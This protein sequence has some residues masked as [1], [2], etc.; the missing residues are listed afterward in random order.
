MSPIR[1]CVEFRCSD[2]EG[3]VT[4]TSMAGLSRFWHWR[5]PSQGRLNLRLGVA[6]APSEKFPRLA[7]S[8][9]GK[10]FVFRGAPLRCAPRVTTPLHRYRMTPR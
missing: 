5:Y 1:A 7:A 8:S 2:K 9:H 6:T 4:V 10:F 3:P